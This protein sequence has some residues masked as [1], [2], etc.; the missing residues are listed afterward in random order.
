MG[1]RALLCS[2][3]LASCAVL[4]AGGP[5]GCHEVRK[6]FHSR[7]VMGQVKWVPETP[8]SG[9]DL[10]VCMSSN[11]TCC[12]RKMEERYQEAA[13]LDIQNLLQTSSS[14][15]K[16]L[17]SR[18]VVAFQEM[19]E[20]IIR[21]AENHTDA[22]FRNTYRSMAFK[23]AELVRELFTDIALF[24]L[25][26]ELGAEDLVRRFFDGL[27]PLAYDRLLE[28]GLTEISAGYAEC[29][30][31]VRQELRPFGAIPRQLAEQ[32]GRSLLPG[33]I[34]L[35]ALNLGIEVI[36]TTD[37]LQY[38]KECR[39]ALLK[40]LYCPHCQ[41]LTHSRPCTGYCL[42]V[43]R[44][45]L[46][47][48]AEVDIHW[49]EF[50]RSLE[51]VS[52]RMQGAGDPEQ[53]LLSIHTL[54]NS[55]VVHVQRNGPRI[56]AQLHRVCG[57]PR[58]KA[59]QSVS[60]EPRD[61]RQVP[62]LWP[63]GREMEESFTRWTKEFLGSLRLYR[64]FYGGLADQLCVS[65]LASE[66]G[67]SCWN[68][69]DVVKSYT[70][71]VVGSGI[72][73]QAVNPEVKVKGA[74]PVIHQIID[75]LKHINQRLQ[76]KAIP[77]NGMLDLIELGS[78]TPEW[79]FSGDCDDEDGCGGSGDGEG[80]NPRKVSNW[81]PEKVNDQSRHGQPAQTLEATHKSRGR[82]TAPLSLLA[83][84]MMGVLTQLWP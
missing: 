82:A 26:S 17:L 3:L 8:R 74:D 14:S 7:H 68:G 23:A 77:T 63:P 6:V 2:L 9:T 60:D 19:M 50:V 78:G 42:N 67:L 66:D 37:H 36:N 43:M 21:Q 79:S 58:R 51:E 83:L 81:T 18:S 75:K 72:K 47:S 52:S 20:N 1:G 56:L 38:G 15:L 32:I 53:V 49:R 45:C 31:A 10:Q 29:V 33:R 13:R 84:G 64:T 59:S 69:A 24:V 28:P 25:G 27:F 41:G 40:M 71:Q 4:S 54:V 76:G 16:M 62:P 73:A 5:S 65:D 55:A 11:L 61:G 34:F 46:A 35:Q 48:A 22:L 70:L 80:I 12:T 39:Q 30:R 44:G 57:H